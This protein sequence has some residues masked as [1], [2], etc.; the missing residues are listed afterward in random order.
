MEASTI[1][2][3]IETPRRVD[4][5]GCAVDPLSIC[6]TVARCDEIIQSGRFSQQVSINAAKVTALHSDRRLRSITRQCNLVSVD[7]Q[8]VVWASKLLG[9]P[10][11]ERVP[12][13]ELMFEL[14]AL[15]ERR[16]Y[17]VYIL[18]ARPDVLE[19]AVVKLHEQ[20]PR[21][22]LCGWH[23]GYFSE[24]QERIIAEEICRTAPNILLV[25]MSSPRKEYWLAEHGPATGAQFGMGVGGSIDVVAGVTRR[26]PEWMQQAGLEWFYRLIQEPKRLGRRYAVTNTMFLG[27]LAAELIRTRIG[28]GTGS[29][30]VQRR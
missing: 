30:D 5:L 12:G 9:C 1:A 15:A 3:T 11:P 19:T 26:A 22:N 10:V 29:T 20:Y 7:G 24:G 6:A 17:R 28:R 13:I 4:V 21:L 18:G 2:P 23:H 25:A 14:L 8:S 27:L 16:G